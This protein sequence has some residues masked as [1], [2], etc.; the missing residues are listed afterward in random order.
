MAIA[1]KRLEIA[2]FEGMTWSVQKHMASDPRRISGITLHID[3]QNPPADPRIVAALKDIALNCPVARSLH[4]DLVQAVT[5][6]F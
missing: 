2:D 1:C 4:P 5:F 6:G 3:W